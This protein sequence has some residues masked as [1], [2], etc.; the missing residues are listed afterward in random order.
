MSPRRRNSPS[1]CARCPPGTRAPS[2][3]SVRDG[4][5]GDHATAHRVDG[6]AGGRS[7]AG[8]CVSGG[9]PEAAGVPGTELPGALAVLAAGGAGVAEAIW[10]SRSISCLTERTG[11]PPG[12][13]SAFPQGRLPAALR[14]PSDRR[15]R[16]SR[17][18]ARAGTTARCPSPAG[19]SPPQVRTVAESASGTRPLGSR[20]GCW[21]SS[22]WRDSNDRA[23]TQAASSAG[24]RSS[25][26]PRR[27]HSAASRSNSVY[28]RPRRRP[29]GVTTSPAR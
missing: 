11:S 1:T 9:A 7:Q 12:V 24:D 2:V 5:V 6:G 22:A 18:R 26:R 15:P 4:R 28:R 8:C 10:S 25:H 27:R 13:R 14:A 29:S 20:G 17:G 23:D 3:R 21:T 16:R 19:R